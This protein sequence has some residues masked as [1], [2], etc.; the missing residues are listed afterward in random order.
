MSESLGK[1]RI[2]RRAGPFCFT[3]TWHAP[4]LVLP[5]HAHAHACLHF[6]LEGG[7]QESMPGGSRCF[8]PGALL[9]KPPGV[10]HSNRFPECGARTLRIELETGFEG[11]LGETGQ[12]PQDAEHTRFAVV[13]RRMLA[14]LAA[15]DDLTPLAL[16]GLGRELLALFFR[17]PASARARVAEACAALLCARFRGRVEL[18]ALAR[19]LGCERTAL[20]R[21]FRARFGASLGEYVRELRVA[22]VM[23]LLDR[24][25]QP[26]AAI[27]L[28]AGFAD[29]SHCT[30]VFRRL[31]G[32]T[33]S[34]WLRTSVPG[35]HGR[36]RP[37]R[38]RP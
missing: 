26:L 17:R 1:D 14:E 11:V 29:Q 13:S 33:P 6:V 10:R 30:R 20:A 9:Y 34:A 21:A 18:R 22:E 8:G 25:E 31:V 35:L 2:E 36:P 3:D 4:A 23:R 32:V 7:Y 16:E 38:A 27:A 12:R 5:P 24:G 37:S 28:E 15:P 19:E